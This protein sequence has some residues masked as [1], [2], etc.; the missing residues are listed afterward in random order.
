MSLIPTLTNL[1]LTG[2]E[3]MLVKRFYDLLDYLIENNYSKNISL[4]ITTNCSVLNPLIINRLEQFK[5]VFIVGSIDA[6]MD[7]A[8]YQRYG[9]QWADVENNCVEY[10]KLK[11]VTFVISST[12][13][14]YTVLDLSKLANFYMELKSLNNN[15][16]WLVNLVLHKPQLDPTILP[17]ELRQRAIYELK[18]SI[19]KVKGL[20]IEKQLIAI[21]ETIQTVDNSN[22]FDDFVAFTKDHDKVRNQSFEKTFGCKLY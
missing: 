10:A 13:T 19:N 20:D 8:E 14:A 18:D 1:Q 11:N 9:T 7:V 22:R 15:V 5:K 16:N 6:V 21:L 2:G 17:V 4:Q 3:P 12:L